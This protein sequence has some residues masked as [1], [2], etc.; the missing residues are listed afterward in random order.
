MTTNGLFS[1]GKRILNYF[2]NGGTSSISSYFLENFSGGGSTTTLT[3][4]SG[5]SSNILH[6]SPLNYKINNVD[7]Y[8]KYIPKCSV[9]TSTSST[10]ILAGARYVVVLLQAAGGN[11]TIYVSSP[12]SGGDSG[13]AGAL[14]VGRINL[15]QNPVTT[16]NFNIN[17]APG[18]SCSI[19]LSGGSGSNISI[20]CVNG[21]NGAVSGGTVSITG[22]TGLSGLINESGASGIPTNGGNS[23][24][25]WVL[26]PLTKKYNTS[27]RFFYPIIYDAL[28]TQKYGDGGNGAAYRGTAELGKPA[29]WSVW[30]LL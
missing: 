8:N 22:T 14:Y 7:I 28:N 20:I 23:A 6:I 26:S 17:N 11:G 15:S 10:S 5:C 18:S 21:N 27:L 29:I 3:D 9:G 25:G 2:D 13:S 1:D 24:M 30:Y 19:V 12:D 16:I 4:S